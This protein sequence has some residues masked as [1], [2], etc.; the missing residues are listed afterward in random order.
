MK[1]RSFIV[2]VCRA[3]VL[4]LLC[5]NVPLKASDNRS[6]LGAELERAVSCDRAAL[7]VFDGSKF[8]GS[9]DDPYPTFLSMGVAIYN[10]PGKFGASVFRFPKGVR[11]FGYE[12]MQAVYSTESITTFFV[13]LDAGPTDLVRL[14]NMLRLR[15][16]EKEDMNKF[17][18]FGKITVRYLKRVGGQN[19]DP[20][21]FQFLGER[22]TN[23]KSSVF[24]GC[25]NLAW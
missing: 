5:S 2:F 10:D 17:G 3:L 24:I 9:S 23:G 13:E 15:P 1:F 12:A 6:Q 8:D 25:Q 7:N 14:K 19:L 22:T 18:Y 11:V 4:M 21:D 16:I 20:P